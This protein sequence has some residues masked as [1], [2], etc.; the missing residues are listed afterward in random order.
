[1]IIKDILISKNTYTSGFSNLTES[2]GQVI[3]IYTKASGTLSRTGWTSQSLVSGGIVGF[4]EETGKTVS[5]NANCV[6]WRLRYHKELHSSAILPANSTIYFDNTTGFIQG[7]HCSLYKTNNGTANSSN[8]KFA[9]YDQANG[10]Y[11]IE[12]K[13]L[14]LNWEKNLLIHVNNYKFYIKNTSLDTE[15]YVFIQNYPLKIT[16]Y[17]YPDRPMYFKIIKEYETL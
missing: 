17:D 14:S 5:Y 7:R 15:Y 3:I 16:S 6:V 12:L 8:I 9:F 10:S 13:P 2:D 4:M 1:M 11:G